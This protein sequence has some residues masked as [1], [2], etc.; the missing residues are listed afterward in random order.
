MQPSPTGSDGESRIVDW[1]TRRPSDAGR[2]QESAENRVLA[3]YREFDTYPRSPGGTGA[4][5]QAPASARVSAACALLD[6]GWGRPPQHVDVDVDPPGGDG[7]ETP[8]LVRPGDPGF[9][10]PPTP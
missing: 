8:R 2:P 9:V 7:E 3:P 10:E 4:A 1:P 6:R 5:R